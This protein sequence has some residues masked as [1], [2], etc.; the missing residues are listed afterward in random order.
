MNIN[1]DRVNP[2]GSTTAGKTTANTHINHSVGTNTILKFVIQLSPFNALCYTAGST[3]TNNDAHTNA[4]TNV[5][6]KAPTSA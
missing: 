2:L 1:T 6:T 5:N 4:N 3:N